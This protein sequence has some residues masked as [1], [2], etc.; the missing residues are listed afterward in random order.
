M[1][2]DC[3]LVAFQPYSLT[4]HLKTLHGLIAVGKCSV[5]GLGFH[6]PGSGEVLQGF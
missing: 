3:R 5:V 6:F 1:S 2:D 4:Q